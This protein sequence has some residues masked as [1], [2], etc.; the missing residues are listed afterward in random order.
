[1]NCVQRRISKYFGAETLRDMDTDSELL[2]TIKISRN[3]FKMK[4]PQATYDSITYA[5]VPSG[6]HN[7]KKVRSNQL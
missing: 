4:L 7:Q 2:K 6:A 3:I 1:M 5:T